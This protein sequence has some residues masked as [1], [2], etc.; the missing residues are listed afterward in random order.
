MGRSLLSA[1]FILI[2]L[3]LKL[4]G[5]PHQQQADWS[6]GNNSQDEDSFLLETQE[7][8]QNSDSIANIRES[9]SG[10]H[11][12]PGEREI[13]DKIFVKS[14]ATENIEAE[15]DIVEG[16]C[17]VANPKTGTQVRNGVDCKDYGNC[18]PLMIIIMM[19][20]I[21]MMMMMTMM[22]MS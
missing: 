6:K 19:M 4:L 17:N 11:K 5:W 7:T 20:M 22:M 16:S 3:L 1:A 12:R 2:L 15:N 9:I 14:N 8:Q 10:I 18:M 13:D 21:M